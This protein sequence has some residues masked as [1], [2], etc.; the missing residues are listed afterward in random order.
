MIYRINKKDDIKYAI[1]VGKDVL[2]NDHS[3]ET[4]NNGISR[5]IFDNRLCTPDMLISYDKLNDDI[6]ITKVYDYGNKTDYDY[7]YLNADEFKDDILLKGIL[8]QI[9]NIR[10]SKSAQKMVNAYINSDFDSINKNIINIDD[11]ELREYVFQNRNDIRD[12]IRLNSSKDF[13]YGICDAGYVIS[14]LSFFSSIPL[15]ISLDNNIP[16]EVLLISCMTMFGFKYLK[17]YRENK[18]VLNKLLE[19]YSNSSDKDGI[20]RKRKVQE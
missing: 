19:M 15:S 13:L 2:F 11:E 16:F 1:S 9:D 20:V 8:L 10:I 18:L 7:M 17:D 5:F 6:K 12:V 4:D 3:I 14:F